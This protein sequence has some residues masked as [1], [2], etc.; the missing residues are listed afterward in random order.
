MQYFD[1]LIFDISSLNNYI[2][3]GDLNLLNE[4]INQDTVHWTVNALVFLMLSCTLWPPC[5]FYK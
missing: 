4:I 3:P 1:T 5:S 2:H